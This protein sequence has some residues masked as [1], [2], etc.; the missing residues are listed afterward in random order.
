MPFVGASGQELFRMLGEAMPTVNPMLHAEIVELFRYG[1]AWVRRRDEWFEA[2][3]VGLTNVFDFQPAGNKIESLCGNKKE[4]SNVLDL[5]AIARAMYLRPEY[6]PELARLALELDTLRP[7]LVVAL[8][9]T[10]CWALLR[11]TNIGMLRGTAT[12]GA[13]TSGQAGWLGKVLPTYHPAAVLRMWAWRPI[14]VA[15][16]TKAAREAQFAEIRRPTRRIII[17]PTIAECE[18]W[19]DETLIDPPPMLSVDIETGAGQI[20]CISFARTRSEAIVI[21]FVDLEVSSGSVWPTPDE[22]LVAWNVVGRLLNCP[23]VKLG[24]NFIYDLQYLT[25][26]G[27]APRACLEDTMLLHHSLFPELQK[28]LGFLG[29]VYTNEASWKLMNRPKADTEKADE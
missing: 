22:E 2:A 5:P 4:T 17:N 24:Q 23:S 9:N 11:A 20:K 7:N 14:V 1:L 25:R 21:P 12:C 10:A 8:G 26:M 13:M 3:G 19:A 27:F 18:A 15:D 29:S 6:L 28:G 16:L